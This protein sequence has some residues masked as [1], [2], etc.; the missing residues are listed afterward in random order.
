MKDD[1]I[2]SGVTRL[3]ELPP[4]LVERLVHYFSTYKMRPGHQSTAKVLGTYGP[5]RAFEVIRE[6]MAHYAQALK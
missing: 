2:W 1:A 4:T 6:S 3:D 5:D